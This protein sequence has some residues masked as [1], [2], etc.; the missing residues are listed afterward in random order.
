MSRIAGVILAA[1][2]SSRLGEPKQLL[3]LGG[4]PVLAHTLAAVRQTSLDPLAI[5]LGHAAAEIEQRV[6]LRDVQTIH[7]PDYQSGQSS[8]IRAALAALSDDIDGVVFILGDQ[9]L[10]EPAVIDRLVRAFRTEDA[11]IVQPKYHEGRGN[12]VLIARSLFSE[13]AEVTGDTG[14]RPLIQRH[15]DAVRLVDATEFSRPDDIDTRED[16]ENILREFAARCDA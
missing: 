13:L 4:R 1:G 15:H 5:V 2:S 12:P 6:D 14:A 3:D 16:Y 10:V 9:P 11:P 7:N 8:S